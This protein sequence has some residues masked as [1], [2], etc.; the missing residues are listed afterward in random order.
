MTKQCKNI[1]KDSIRN[2]IKIL[3][4]VMLICQFQRNACFN[5]LYKV[6]KN[7]N[8]NYSILMS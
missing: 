4:R 3:K 7:F 1:K 6:L 8:K 5:Y 2:R